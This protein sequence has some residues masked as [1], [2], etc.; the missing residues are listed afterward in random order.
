MKILPSK[1]KEND[2]NKGEMRRRT[3]ANGVEKGP[4]PNQLK[5]T[6]RHK[7]A[8]YDLYEVRLMACAWNREV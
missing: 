7:R 3:G 2:E 5:I 1:K 6:M 4:C 8:G